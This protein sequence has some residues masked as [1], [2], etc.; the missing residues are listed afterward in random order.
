MQPD[1][2]PPGHPP[3]FTGG[4]LVPLQDNDTDEA[5][6]PQPP[7]S[8][9]GRPTPSSTRTNTSHGGSSRRERDPD[10]PPRPMNAWLLFRTAQLKQIQADN[11]GIKKSQGEL[12]KIISEMWKSCDPEIR[13]SYE[14]LA[15]E[16]KLEHQRAYPDYRYSPTSRNAGPSGSSPSSSAGAGRTPRSKRSPTL[17]SQSPT[18]STSR[19]P[20]LRLSPSQLQVPR[21]L[22]SSAPSSGEA[23]Y[24]AAP[25]PSP[26]GSSSSSSYGVLPTPPPGLTYTP[27][28]ASSWKPPA[29]E[30]RSAASTILTP[31]QT[32]GLP[33]QAPASSWRGLQDWNKGHEGA[34][35]MQ[36]EQQRHPRAQYASHGQEEV[37]QHRVPQSAPPTMLRFDAGPQSSLGLSFGGGEVEQ[38]SL[39]PGTLSPTSL[40]QPYQSQQHHPPPQPPYS[41]PSS[42]YA[43]HHRPSLPT[44]TMPHSYAVVQQHTYTSVAG[45]GEPYAAVAPSPGFSPP[46]AYNASPPP[47]PWTASTSPTWSDAPMQP[48]HA[49]AHAQS[50]V[51]MHHPQPLP[52]PSAGA[53]RL[54]S[55]SS[56]Y[57]TS[58]GPPPP[59]AMSLAS[60]SGAPSPLSGPASLGQHEY[61]QQ[62]QDPAGGYYQGY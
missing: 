51:Q 41:D 36:H 23:R 17:P 53:A 27:Y 31:P 35:G 9:L 46:S 1:R 34:Q 5:E 16:R 28:H 8:S 54:R 45:A 37:V 22:P 12:S 26:A 29:Q 13:A 33:G 25:T 3:P 42:V 39:P 6:A 2:G 40:Y 20:S 56:A 10:R 18:A 32:A 58:P 4:A 43:M 19:K 38:Q 61:A 47:S 11:P 21:S 55:P 7:S 62:A 59:T 52:A 24:A 60:S 48:V 49:H 44:S 30:A 57:S 50:P 14:A 15:K